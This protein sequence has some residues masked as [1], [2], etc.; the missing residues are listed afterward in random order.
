MDLKVRAE[1][2]SVGTLRTHGYVYKYILILQ[3]IISLESVFL[4]CVKCIEM[5]TDS[6]PPKAL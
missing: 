2:S 5:L 6:L 3:V 1:E 4:N